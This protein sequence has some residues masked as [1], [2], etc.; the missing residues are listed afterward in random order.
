VGLILL[1]AQMPG[2]GHGGLDGQPEPGPACN[3][4]R[5]VSAHVNAREANDRHRSGNNSASGRAEPREGRRAHG[6][7]DARVP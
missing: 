4:Q 1:P 3:V 7:R 5:E 6:E 2:Q